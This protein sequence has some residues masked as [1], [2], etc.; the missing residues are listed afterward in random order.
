MAA[1]KNGGKKNNF[2]VGHN[3]KKNS[4]FYFKSSCRPTEYQL[5]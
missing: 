1:E 2:F 4:D 3:I 5:R